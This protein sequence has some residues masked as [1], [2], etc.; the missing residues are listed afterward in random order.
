MS[1]NPEDEVNNSHQ[2]RILK[3]WM[4]F[5]NITSLFE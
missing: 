3:T 5:E 1:I 2:T 4:I